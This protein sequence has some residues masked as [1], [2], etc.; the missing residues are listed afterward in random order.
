MTNISETTKMVYDKLQD[1][2]S[3]MIFKHRLLFFLDRDCRHLWDMS[4]QVEEIEKKMFPKKQN[5][6]YLIEKIKRSG[7]K[8]VFFFDKRPRYFKIISYFNY[9]GMDINLYFPLESNMAVSIRS[10]FI[11]V[12]PEELST[13]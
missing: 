9:L 3:R 12:H 11:L 4:I 1:D 2:E 10:N 8:I 5:Q 13:I 7:K 6:S